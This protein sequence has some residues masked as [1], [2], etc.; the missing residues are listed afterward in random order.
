MES[1]RSETETITD[2]V[3][4]ARPVVVERGLERD[5][6]SALGPA[7]PR[8]VQLK[9][10]IDVLGLKVREIAY[11][12]NVSEQTVRNWRKSNGGEHPSNFDD[13]RALAEILVR[14][15]SL[16]PGL[17]GSW[18]RSRNRGLGYSRPLEAV[19]DGGFDQV[20]GVAQ[21]FGALS[22]PVAARSPRKQAQ[23]EAEF[24]PKLDADQELARLTQ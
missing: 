15:D 17:I 19:R 21:S 11:A 8:S 23:A 2:D 6:L 5:L 18:F 7:S 13:L 3:S 22:P 9:A 1:Q 14:A 24:V 4:V 10:M 16:S 20:M 12:S